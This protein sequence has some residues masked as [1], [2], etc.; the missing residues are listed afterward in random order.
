MCLHVV[1]RKLEAQEG[2]FW[3]VFDQTNKGRLFTAIRGTPIPRSRWITA[4]WRIA[5]NAS[6]WPWSDYISGFHGFA[7]KT[8]AENSCLW[9]CCAY[10]AVLLACRYRGRVTIGT[11]HGTKV[12]VAEEMMVLPRNRQPEEADNDEK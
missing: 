11:E 4:R 7:S 10:R 1:E 8:D 3:K 5:L 2:V 9:K 6:V 12:I